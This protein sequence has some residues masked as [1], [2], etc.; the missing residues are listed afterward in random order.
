MMADRE[1]RGISVYRLLIVEDEEIILDGLCRHCPWEET[2]FVVVASA[3]DGREAL[4]LIEEGLMVDAV[5][6]D[7]R[8]EDMDGLAL[9]RALRESGKMMPVVLLSGYDSFEYAKEGIGH[10]AFDYLLK[11]SSNAVI[12]ETFQRVRAALDRE[13]AHSEHMM[14][15]KHASDQNEQLKNSELIAR[16]L[17]AHPDREIEIDRRLIEKHMRVDLCV[18]FHIDG[19]GAG[20]QIGVSELIEQKVDC[21]GLYLVGCVKASDS[22][23]LLAYG[24]E[25]GAKADFFRASARIRSMLLEFLYGSIP[26]SALTITTAHT[27]SSAGGVQSARSLC[28]RALRLL[29]LRFFS[30]DGVDYCD[31]DWRCHEQSRAGKSFFTNETGMHEDIGYPSH[32][33]YGARSVYITACLEEL[34][35]TA[36]TSDDVYRGLL[37]LWHRQVAHSAPEDI[38]RTAACGIEPYRELRDIVENGHMP[39]AINWFNAVMRYSTPQHKEAPP[40]RN[41]EAIERVVQHIRDN[42]GSE[43]SLAELAESEFMSMAYFSVLFK[44]FTG[45]SYIHFLLDERVREAKRLLKENFKV[46]EVAQRV[47]YVDY[48]HFSRI[49]IKA[50]GM[51]PTE[52]RRGQEQS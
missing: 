44:R 15:L 5:L 6:T 13:R 40:D 29:G 24:L 20:D 38:D 23:F 27:D 28:E 32:D 12:S 41:R 30:E 48:R 22:S 47:G 49:F 8:M 42:L 52:Y 14:T 37:S 7:I 1:Q 33:G 19:P 9:L 35:K 50:T 25:P 26:D 2:G 16:L 46:Y 10:G 4:R 34:E 18:A 45:V 11:P 36:L 51:K 39:D 3:R 21:A 17:K 31:A 43:L